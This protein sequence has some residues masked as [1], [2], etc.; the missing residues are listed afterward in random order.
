MTRQPYFLRP[1][2]AREV[3][4][5]KVWSQSG[6]KGE[7]HWGET[8]KNTKTTVCFVVEAMTHRRP[9]VL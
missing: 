8:L 1:R 2:V 4:D 3:F 7:G 9:L 5:Q 6:R